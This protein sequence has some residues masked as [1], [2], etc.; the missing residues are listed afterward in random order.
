M[1]LPALESGTSSINENYYWKIDYYD[2]DLALHSSD[3]ANPALTIL[4]LTIMLVDEY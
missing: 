3:P 2:Q 4:V 1:E